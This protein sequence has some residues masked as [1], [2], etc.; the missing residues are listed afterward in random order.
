MNR[1]NIKKFEDP[2]LW[3]YQNVLK[4]G[5]ELK[6]GNVFNNEINK[7]AKEKLKLILKECR[8]K[9][10]IELKELNSSRKEV[11]LLNNAHTN[12]KID[13]S[14]LTFNPFKEK[15]KTLNLKH[16]LSETSKRCEYISRIRSGN[17]GNYG[18]VNSSGNSI[19][20][21]SSHSSSCSSKRNENWSC[22]TRGSTYN[23]NINDHQNAEKAI[24]EKNK[25]YA[26]IKK[27][28]FLKQMKEIK[29]ESISK[30]TSFFNNYMNYYDTHL[31]EKYMN[32]YLNNYEERNKLKDDDYQMNEPQ[33]E[34]N[35]G[36]S[37]VMENGNTTGQ[38]NIKSS[39]N[40]SDNF[41]TPKEVISREGYTYQLDAYP[42]HLNEKDGKQN[43][44]N[45]IGDRYRNVI[46][47]D[48]L[49]IKNNVQLEFNKT[50]EGGPNNDNITYNKKIESYEKQKKKEKKK[51]EYL[52]IN[53]VEDLSKGTHYD[54]NIT[55]L[56][57]SYNGANNSGVSDNSKI[58]GD[59]IHGRQDSE[60][61]T[62]CLSYP[63]QNESNEYLNASG[64]LKETTV[65][66]KRHIGEY[67][68][69]SNNIRYDNDYNDNNNNSNS[70]SNSNSNN[71]NNNSNNNN[72]N[73]NNNNSNNNNSN[74]NNSNNNYY[75]NNSSNRNN[76][77]DNNWEEER[78]KHQLMSNKTKQHL[79]HFSIFEKINN[80][81]LYSNIEPICPTMG[82]ENL[83]IS[84]ILLNLREKKKG[85]KMNKN[86][87]VA[88][89]SNKITC[90]DATISK[91]REE[92]FLA[93]SNFN[94]NV[95]LYESRK[96]GEEELHT[97]GEKSY[98]VKIAYDKY[99]LPNLQNDSN[100][101][102]KGYIKQYEYLDSNNITVNTLGHHLNIE[103]EKIIN[104]CKYI[105]DNDYINKYTRLE[106]EVA[107]LVCEELNVLDKLRYSCISLRK[108]NPIV[109]ILGHVDHGKTTLLDQFR[110]SNI[111]KNEI[112]GITQKLGAF[113]VLDRKTN[114]KIT[115]LDTPGHAVFKKIRQRCVQCTDLIIL[116]ISI[117]DGIMSETV[118]CIQLAKKYNIPLIIA[119]N[120]IDKYNSNVEKISKSLL[121]Y[122]IITELENGSVP[123]IPISAKKN[124]N[125]DLLQ[126]SI[127][128]VSDKLNLVCDYG[129][130][131]SAYVLEKKVDAA[132]GKLLTVI[133]KSGILKV[134]SYILIGHVY[135][136]IKRIFNSDDKIVK[137]AYPSE[138]VQIVCSI[139][140]SDDSI[141][142]GDMILEMTNLKSAQ[143]IAKYK[144]KILQYKLMNNYY[145]EGDDQEETFL[146]R[147]SEKLYDRDEDGTRERAP[148][149][150]SSNVSTNL[151]FKRINYTLKED[152]RGEEKAEAKVK[153]N[154][155]VSVKDRMVK[156]REGR[157][158]SHLELP[159]VP[160][161]IKTCDEGSIHA[162]IEGIDEFTKSEK[163]KKYC[164]INNFIDRN[165]VD[166]N[167]LKKEKLENNDEIFEK[168]KPFKIITKGVGTFNMS[169]LKY[170][171]Y[172]KP[173]FLFAFNVD[174]D[175]KVQTFIESNKNA[176]LRNHNII[177]ELFQDIENVC[178]FYFDSLH[179]YESV[180]RMIVNKT[181]SYS[182]K[183]NKAPK[184][185]VLSVDIKEG[186][187]N[188]NNY[189][190][191]LRN[192]QIIHKRLTILS[193][194]K[195]KQS[196]TELT[197]TCNVN[198]IIFNT[199]SE[200]FEIGD[201]IIAYK[202]V[203]RPPLFN[204]IKSFDLSC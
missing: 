66:K 121:N 97:L 127:L 76:C 50:T 94:E 12:K 46:N 176:I 140:F 190:T 129:T 75:N 64:K 163:K 26:E 187:C 124:I 82:D 152:K 156:R 38:I 157:I 166:K 31:K 62:N 202:K 1:V 6:K 2:N 59:I 191:V 147:E 105:L 36:K 204:K 125:I 90:A 83:S 60:N 23:S 84:S 32:H 9:Y 4:K 20:Y 96:K 99:I 67:N 142:Y 174:I 13:I 98:E 3:L 189:F 148:S 37:Y 106:K 19:S 57:E 17:G 198:A 120:K 10:D 40:I 133:G 68:N 14:A 197:K 168:W 117:D 30:I 18:N 123:I 167:F 25:L 151:V 183:K 93:C 107:E 48:R 137:E 144:L 29:E 85:T 5:E 58:Y 77:S 134:N 89:Y 114:K 7:N 186:S 195:N 111:A 201:E 15:N 102:G 154:D 188:T 47:E 54:K 101:K 52:N 132:K 173:C 21:N 39:N 56:E 177:Y 175:N 11:T 146:L 33:V 43:L 141:K 24:M 70:N 49:N 164:D 130:L 112:G 103:E 136:K 172:V 81:S 8:E 185:K 122:E 45:H 169:E 88:S 42:V 158:E 104:V 126:K 193:M 138:V 131:S 110:N 113:E 128:D 63:S 95:L 51:Q 165:Y 199:N 182:L 44:P 194:Q 115:F 22:N 116:V 139:S 181:G 79:N 153:T 203:T 65:M 161:I 35:Y 109:T 100:K 178:N 87:S 179:I 180:S 200:D 149:T 71:N 72:S 184:K 73:S 143:K 135:T 160:L 74:N 34:M 53:N 171:E 61:S 159:Q 80:T 155:S 16:I 91:K 118:E 55:I 27:N 92:N 28:D 69:T 162:I 86:N 196:A 108:R 170:C 41:S 150:I 78:Y 145:L 192:K 119:V